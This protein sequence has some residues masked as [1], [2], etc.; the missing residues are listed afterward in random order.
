MIAEWRG[1]PSDLPRPDRARSTGELIPKVMQKLG[2]GE[3]LQET[4]IL[5]AWA[6]IVGE[7]NATHS[8]PIALR[9]GNALCP[10]AATGAALRAGPNQQASDSAQ[11]ET[12]LRRKKRSA[13]CVSVSAERSDE[14]L[15]ANFW[16]PLC[17]PEPLEKRPQGLLAHV[18]FDPFGIRFRDHGWHA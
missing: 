18:M 13:I 7:F 17:P 11:V 9:E 4:E 8:S 5:G 10:G 16:M 3:R 12:A 6:A 14:A 1:L 15:S 2:L